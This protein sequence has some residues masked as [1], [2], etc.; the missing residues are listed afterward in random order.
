MKW[1]LAMRETSGSRRT[2]RRK[3]RILGY[4]E[5]NE[6][7]LT[8]CRSTR[9]PRISADPNSTSEIPVIGDIPD[10]DD[11]SAG[12]S[13]HAVDGLSS[14]LADTSIQ[15]DDIPDL[16]DI[17]DMDDEDAIGGGLIEEEDDAA[18]KVE[19]VKKEGGRCVPFDSPVRRAV[20]AVAQGACLLV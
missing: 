11:P 5:Q 18:V 14:H 9:D 19:P 12:S 1:L 17:P 4:P 7:R 3:V 8:T 6:L 13:S 10:V 2:L 20:L 16:D 15:A